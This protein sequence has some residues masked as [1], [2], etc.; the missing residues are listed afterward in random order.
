MKCEF[1]NIEFKP[2]NENQTVCENCFP[3]INELSNGKGDDNE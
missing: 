3:S 2:K 1:C